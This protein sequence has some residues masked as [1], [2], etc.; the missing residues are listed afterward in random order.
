[1]NFSNLALNRARIP[2]VTQITRTK[3]LTFFVALRPNA[4][5]D[6]LILEVSR[7]HTTRTT[8]GRSPLDE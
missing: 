6:L 5:H 3:A 8:V 4:G 1:M 2:T 7:S